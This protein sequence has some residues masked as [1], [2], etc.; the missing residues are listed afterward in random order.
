MS[1]EEKIEQMAKEALADI[2]QMVDA[3]MRAIG[4]TQPFINRSRAQR[5]RWQRVREQKG[6]SV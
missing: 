3:G 1:V 4:F 5:A 6:V 2:R